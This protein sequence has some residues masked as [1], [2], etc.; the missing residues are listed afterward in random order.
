M[1]VEIGRIKRCLSTAEHNAQLIDAVRVK[2]L[3]M[4][5]DVAKEEDAGRNDWKP[6]TA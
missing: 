2:S 5:G 3:A 6:S 4:Q 1:S